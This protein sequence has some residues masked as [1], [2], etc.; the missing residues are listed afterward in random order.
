M[1]IIDY[2]KENNNDKHVNIIIC[3]STIEYNF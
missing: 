2:C 1:V 3:L